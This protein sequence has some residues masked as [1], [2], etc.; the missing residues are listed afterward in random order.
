MTAREHWRAGRDHGF[1]RCCRARFILDAKRPHTLSRIGIVERLIHLL[2]PRRRLADGMVPCEMHALQWLLTGRREHW[3]RPN[4]VCCETRRDL[5]GHANI[6][7]VEIDPE[8]MGFEG[9]MNVAPM[10]VWMFR[11]GEEE[12]SVGFCPWCGERL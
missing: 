2:S 7:A 4:P 3:R 1:P 10:R 12:I 5:R 9:G 6:E 8:E 11:I